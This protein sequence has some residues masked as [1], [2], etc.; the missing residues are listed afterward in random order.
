LIRLSFCRVLYLI[1]RILKYQFLRVAILKRFFEVLLYLAYKIRLRKVKPWVLLSKFHRRTNLTALLVT[2]L[3][4]RSKT[5]YSKIKYL[6]S[7]G[8]LPHEF[9]LRKVKPWVLKQISLYSKFNSFSIT[10]M[11]Q[12]YTHPTSAS[13][14]PDT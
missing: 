14:E 13:E 9:C 6:I 4:S 1:L 5:K 11:W 3:G 2:I 7:Y 10:N 8:H 12:V